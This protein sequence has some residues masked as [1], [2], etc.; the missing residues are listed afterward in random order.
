MRLG[1]DGWKRNEANVSAKGGI[2]SKVTDC[3]VHIIAYL[4]AFG[5]VGEL[6]RRDCAPV[7]LTCALAQASGGFQAVAPS[8]EE[9]YALPAQHSSSHRMSHSCSSESKMRSGPDPLPTST[10]ANDALPNA[11]TYPTR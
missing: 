1:A 9:H 6:G 4:D 2:E 5:H 7:A 10:F 11:L 3:G 8:P